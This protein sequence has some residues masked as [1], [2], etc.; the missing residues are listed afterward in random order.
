MG[1]ECV[2]CGQREIWSFESIVRPKV[3]LECI[4]KSASWKCKEI[5]EHR[6]LQKIF[7]ENE[8]TTTTRLKRLHLLN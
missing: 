1:F 3:C 4:K 2:L 6:R 8:K 7:N 5:A